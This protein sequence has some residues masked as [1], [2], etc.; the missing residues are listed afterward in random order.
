M[1]LQG[2]ASCTLQLFLFLSR[3]TR[4]KQEQV[5]LGPPKEALPWEGGPGSPPCPRQPQAVGKHRKG[6]LQGM[7][8][9]AIRNSCAEPKCSG[10]HTV[11]A[12][13]AWALALGAPLPW[14]STL[15]GLEFSCQNSKVSEAGHLE[16]P[17][18]PHQD[19]LERKVSFQLHAKL[20]GRRDQRGP[21]LCR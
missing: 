1:R 20:S 4:I 21:K 18:L 6:S 14:L 13:P 10:I 11:T 5:L 19:F 15:K 3:Q 8:H 7:S 17:P 2:L 12:C 9:S 16:A